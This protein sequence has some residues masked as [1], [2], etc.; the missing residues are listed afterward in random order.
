MTP[1]ENPD[2]RK[3]SECAKK[4]KKEDGKTSAEKKAAPCELDTKTLEKVNGAGDFNDLP[5][6]IEHPYD[7]EDKDRY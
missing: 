3:T 2:K 1:K 6:I 7:P 4:A 5:G